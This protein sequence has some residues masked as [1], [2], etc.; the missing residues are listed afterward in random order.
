M[1]GWRL[2]KTPRAGAARGIQFLLSASSLPSRPLHPPSLPSPPSVRVVQPGESTVSPILMY[3][4]GRGC[5]LAFHRDPGPASIYIALRGPGSGR[6]PAWKAQTH[7]A[8]L[9]CTRLP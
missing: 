4:R 9:C 6:D 2:E 5:P 1:P 8:P 3:L 7:S